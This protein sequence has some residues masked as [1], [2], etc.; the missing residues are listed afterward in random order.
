M[1]KELLSVSCEE[2]RAV[3]GV[4]AI[5][6]GRLFGQLLGQLLLH[7]G[8]YHKGLLHR[9]CFLW[10]CSRLGKWKASS[11][12]GPLGPLNNR[13]EAGNS[14]EIQILGESF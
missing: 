9:L 8:S 2:G 6:M 7:L 1:P 3:T 14:A 12:T 5:P 13:Q 11:K 10:W 4:T